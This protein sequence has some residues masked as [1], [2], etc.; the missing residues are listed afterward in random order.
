MENSQ[1]PV[2]QP[3]QPS[4]V[5]ASAVAGPPSKSTSRNLLEISGVALGLILIFALLKG[6]PGM[7]QFALIVFAFI[8]A[9]ALIKDIFGR[10]SRPVSQSQITLSNNQQA[11]T[12]K[13]ASAA[14]VVKI[15][16]ITLAAAF[17]VIFVLPY[18][19]IFLLF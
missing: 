17:L 3:A 9:F 1:F 18:V 7:A 12:P 16:G 8:G 5:V 15:A 10:K 11:V 6:V 19:G 13:R 14:H 4:Q 2:P